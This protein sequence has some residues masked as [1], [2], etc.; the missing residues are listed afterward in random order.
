MRGCSS[1]LFSPGYAK[2]MWG[3]TSTA[4]LQWSMETR[5]SATRASDVSKLR[6]KNIPV[7]RNRRV[8]D[9]VIFHAFLHNL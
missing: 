9:R 1:S 8:K 2:E 5:G 7:D 6:T 3:G 4:K